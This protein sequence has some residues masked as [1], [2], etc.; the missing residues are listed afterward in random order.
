M[1]KN[2]HQVRKQRELTRKA[3]Q[4]EKQQRRTARPSA[5]APTPAV[6][7]SDGDP[8]AAPDATGRDAS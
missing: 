7:A 1:R 2:Y 4:Q 8:V 5:V 3:R 6:A